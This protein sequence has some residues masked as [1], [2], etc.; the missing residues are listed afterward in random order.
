[1]EYT[2]TSARITPTFNKKKAVRPSA[3]RYRPACSTPAERILHTA[4]AIAVTSSAPAAMATRTA[5][6]DC[7]QVKTVNAARNGTRSRRTRVIESSPQPS[8]LGDIQVLEGIANAK[9]KQAHHENAH[10]Q[11]EEDSDLD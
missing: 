7:L 10:Q 9:D 4:F 5:R 11:V 6:P 1:M 8:Q 3:L 2:R